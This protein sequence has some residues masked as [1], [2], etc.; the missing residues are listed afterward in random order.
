MKSRKRQKRRIRNIA[1]KSRF[2]LTR[3]K[4]LLNR[5]KSF[6]PRKSKIY[7]SKKSFNACKMSSENNVS[8]TRKS[9]LS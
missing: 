6:L 5:W 9:K 7:L 3:R 8:L 1:R 4:S 2:L